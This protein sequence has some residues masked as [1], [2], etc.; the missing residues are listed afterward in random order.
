MDIHGRDLRYFTAVAEELSFT[1]AAE[2]LFVSQPALSKQIRMLEKHLGVVLFRR[3]RRTVR[4][5]PVGEALLPHAHEVLAAWR[6][7]QEAVEAARDTGLRTLVI[8]MS[9]GPGRGLLPALRAR[10]VSRHPDART[11]LRQVGWADPSAGLADGSSD[12]AFVWLPLP[13]EAR[14][15][16]VVVAREPR[17]VALPRG[18]RLTE[19]AAADPEGA[20]DF[21]D[22]LDEPFLAL[23]P[24]AGPLRD[25]WL[26]LDARDGRP[27]RIG[28]VVAGAEET[29]EAVAGGQGVALLATGNAPLVVRDGV[30]ALPVR[31]LSPSR[32]AVAAARDD[33]RPLVRAYLAAA[34]EAGAAVRAPR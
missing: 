15:R 27:P 19:R 6:A 21:T 5:T 18:H 3:D 23:P 32:L 10:L 14:Y 24:E 30:I 16:Y 34:A 31:G 22:L 4:L 17:V 26:A 12:V 28:G 29:H 13:D 1:R 20:V 11:V 7:A 33:E 9:T 8:G 25:H 2:R